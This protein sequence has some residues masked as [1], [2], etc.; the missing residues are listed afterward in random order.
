MDCFICVL[1][2]WVK[3]YRTLSPHTSQYEEHLSPP[4]WWLLST[5]FAMTPCAQ[6][7]NKCN[8]FWTEGCFPGTYVPGY[9]VLFVPQLTYWSSNLAG[10][11][12]VC[13]TCCCWDCQQSHQFKARRWRTAVYVASSQWIHMFKEF[14]SSRINKLR[15]HLVWQKNSIN[16]PS[17]VWCFDAAVWWNRNKALPPVRSISITLPLLWVCWT[18]RPEGFINSASLLACFVDS[19]HA[20]NDFMVV[21]RGL[22]YFAVCLYSCLHVSLACLP[23]IKLNWPFR[24]SWQS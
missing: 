5:A 7:Q 12:R 1:S 10:K 20:S 15:M 14:S 13:V 6:Q 3:F 11:W 22:T 21:P 9:A 18:F 23:A 17:I 24:S 2:R 19:H 16:I 8:A 4:L